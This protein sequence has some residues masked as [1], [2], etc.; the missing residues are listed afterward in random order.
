MTSHLFCNRADS[1][2]AQVK[3]EQHTLIS[4]FKLNSFK[5]C[6][7]KHLRA[8]GRE[9]AHA[10]RRLFDLPKKITIYFICIFTLLYLFVLLFVV[11]L[12]LF[13]L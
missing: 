8:R 7:F 1:A 11:R 9:L 6:Q 12:F 3:P 10:V 13:S 4:V 5:P 2:R